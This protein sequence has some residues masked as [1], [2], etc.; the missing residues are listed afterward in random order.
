MKKRDTEIRAFLA[1]AGLAFLLVMWGC[2]G[3][4]GG[5]STE[6]AHTG[7]ARFTFNFG[8][9]GA[10]AMGASAAKIPS[11]TAKIV[12]EVEGT[13]VPPAE[14]TS[15]SGNSTVT[16][17]NIP[18]GKQKF[19]IIAYDASGNVVAHRVEP[20]I[21]Y[22]GEITSI[23][24]SLGMTITP[25]GVVPS[26]MTFSIG[27]RFY[28]K[29]DSGATRAV[30]LLSV[31]STQEVNT[32]GSANGAILGGGGMIRCSIPSHGVD[33]T[34]LSYLA[35]NNMTVKVMVDNVQAATLTVE[36]SASA[37]SYSG[38]MNY[39]VSTTEGEAPLAVDF[40]SASQ[41]ATS[42]NSFYDF[43][44]PYATSTTATGFGATHT[45]EQ[46]GNY[47]V[48]HTIVNGSNTF[49]DT[50]HITVSEP[51]TTTT[52]PIAAA[53]AARGS[54]REDNHA[55]FGVEFVRAFKHE[56]Y[57]DKEFSMVAEYAL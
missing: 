13:D 38:G 55:E 1:L 28:I 32:C 39:R 6:L 44:D 25:T 40:G 26:T 27:D 42:T 14:I 10:R 35:S 22:E 47:T 20:A 43:G 49:T 50:I 34:M 33:S 54:S 57:E 56:V 19:E 23:R 7:K 8:T 21:I 17:I 52:T 18:I 5:G 2:G 9:G 12:I 51:V 41:G 24:A 53:P 30:R 37:T 48:T 46:P 31:L 11:N 16:I 15:L 45:F 3:G 29:N 4:G 36:Q